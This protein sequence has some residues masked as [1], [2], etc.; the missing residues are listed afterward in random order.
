MPKARAKKHAKNWFQRIPL[1]VK[2][3]LTILIIALLV[4]I[5]WRVQ[6]VLRKQSVQKSLEQPT[7]L[8]QHETGNAIHILIHLYRT[9]PDIV[10]RTIFGAFEAAKYPGRIHIHLFQELCLSD[11]YPRDAFSVYKQ[12]YAPRHSWDTQRFSL[13]RNVHVVNENP[14]Q[15]VGRVVSLLTLTQ[16]SVLPMLRASDLVIIPQAFYDLPGTPHLFPATFAQDYDVLLNKAALSAHTVYSGRLPRTSLS[17]SSAAQMTRMTSSLTYAIGENLVVPFLKSKQHAT[18]LESRTLGVCSAAAA[19]NLYIDQ[20]GFTSFATSDRVISPTVRQ[21]TN[22]DVPFTIFRMMRD[23]YAP[24]VHDDTIDW[25]SY[26]S[27]HGDQ[28]SRPVP[29]V[30]I[31]EDVLICTGQTWTQFAQ[32]ARGP[33][34]PHLV[35]GPEYTQTIVLSNLLYAAQLAMLSSNHLPILVVFD[36]LTGTSAKIDLAALNRTKQ[37]EPHNWMVVMQLDEAGDGQLTP[38]MM[39]DPCDILVLEPTFQTYAGVSVDNVTQ[40][41]FIGL[42]AHDGPNIITHKFS[43][44]NELERQRRILASTQYTV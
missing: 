42:T 18:F 13:E 22:A 6:T 11:G 20:S 27:E 31:H 21:T 43:S 39:D 1:T 15:S 28:L 16:E 19:R 41:G 8:T 34:R 37:F 9:P 25:T 17:A 33:G 23:F 10:A 7:V 12:V 2:I 38:V 40:N 24:T 29:L 26:S 44:S 3:G 5:Y 35:P 4:V 14:S 32:F 30:G 36:H